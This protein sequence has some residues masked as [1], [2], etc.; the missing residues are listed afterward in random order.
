MFAKKI[1]C[2]LLCV[3]MYAVS[4]Y[5][6][7]ENKNDFLIKG[8]HLDLRIQV[9]TMDALRSFAMKLKQSGIN[10]LIMEWEATYP[11]A[12]HPL[13]PNRYA[14]TKDEIVSF[15]KFCCDLGIDVVPLQQSFG[16]VEYILRHSRYKELREDQKN[17]SQV[18]PSQP[19]LNKKLFTD[20]FTELVSTHR[21]KYFH[22]GGD[23]TYL[24]GH[25]PLCKK[26]AATEGISKLYID[27]IRMLC[28]IVIKLGKRPVLWADIALKHPEALP[29]LPKETIFIDW[30]YGWDLNYFGDHSKLLQSGFEIWGAPA[31]RS[32]PDNYFLTMWEKHFR[33]IHD[34]VPAARKMNYKGIVMTAWSTSGEYDTRWESSSDIFDLYAIRHVYPITAFNMLVAAFAESIR[35]SPPL[36]ADDFVEKYCKENYGLNADQ[37]HSFW[38]ALRTAPYEVEQGKVIAK[39]NTSI[40][41]LLDSARDAAKIL[42]SFHP[43]KNKDE[44]DQYLLM[45]DIRVQYL[46]YEKIEE[47]V[48]DPAFS[49]DKKAGIISRLKNLMT[50]AGELDKRFIALNR[51]FYYESELQEENRLR[52]LKT[53]S[54][55]DRL[56][57][58]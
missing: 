35:S 14:Y 51:N 32:H 56:V 5:S 18:C 44:F 8:F 25:C 33:N 53:N 13:I 6:Q 10:T 37:A 28:D 15:I 57:K 34:F 17:Y 42:S 36:S 46:E 22:I 9:M 29:L 52:N 26:K 24:L 49:E 40:T 47:E 23:E 27:H 20:L 55:Y 16:H 38:K 43:E 2:I 19:E 31:L 48:N 11:F 7:A 21:S 54:L 50:N 41:Q 12:G 30:N 4:V 1:A 45:A 58:R 39:Q 3:S